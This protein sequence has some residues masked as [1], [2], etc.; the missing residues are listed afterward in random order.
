[1]T[2]AIC[3]TLMATMLVWFSGSMGYMLANP[4]CS[5]SAKVDPYAAYDCLANMPVALRVPW[6]IGF[7]LTH[8]GEE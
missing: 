3:I 5:T 4:Q 7:N 6:M 2:K 8:A 1:M